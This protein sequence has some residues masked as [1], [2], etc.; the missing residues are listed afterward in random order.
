LTGAASVV[1]MVVLVLVGSNK[2]GKNI[3]IGKV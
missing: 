1:D 2:A 3:S